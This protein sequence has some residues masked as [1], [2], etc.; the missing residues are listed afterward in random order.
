MIIGGGRTVFSKSSH[1]KAFW[2]L[3]GILNPNKQ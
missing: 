3:F 1:L 2:L